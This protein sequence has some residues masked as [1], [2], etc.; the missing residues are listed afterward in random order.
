MLEHSLIFD[1]ALPGEDAQTADMHF[2]FVFTGQS[3]P[4]PSKMQVLEGFRGGLPGARQ[5]TFIFYWFLQWFLASGAK[6]CENHCKNQG[7]WASMKIAKNAR[8]FVNFS[9]LG[10]SGGPLGAR[11]GSQVELV[12]RP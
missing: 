10:L 6:M 1:G 2:L 7:F 8:T 11:F 12:G 5:R 9:V 3:G 4:D